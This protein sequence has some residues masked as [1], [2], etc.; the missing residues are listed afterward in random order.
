MNTQ[1]QKDFLIH[2]AYWSLIIAAVYL[3][4][5]YLLPVSVPFILGILIAWL[6]VQI[7]RRIH[8]SSK[9]LRIGIS[10]LIYGLIGALMT[11]IL[12]KSISSISNIL[13]WLPGIYEDK[14]LPFVTL[15]YD[16]ITDR[17]HMMGPDVISTLETLVDDLL[18]ALKNVIAY[19]SGAAV[20][21]VSGIATG[22]PSLILSILAMIFSTMFVVADYEQILS[23]A[24]ENTP[25]HIKKVLYNI[26]RYLTDTLFVVI[27]S[28]VLIMLLTFTEL[29][30]L[31]SLFDF[32]NSVPKAAIIAILDILP[33]LGTGAVMIPWMVISFAL[34]STSLG[35]KLLVIYVIVT[36]VRNY[37]EPKIVGAQLGQHP[38]I[39]L[40][41]M[42]I[43][44]RLFGFWGLFGLPVGISFLWKQYREKQN[45]MQ[46]IEK[47]DP[48]TDS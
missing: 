15:C 6:V 12:A 26:R 14:L 9:L 36:V 35:L 43:G 33:I 47:T 29:T 25:K 22:V 1:Q 46:T 44:L 13:S 48:E 16:W 2:V 18:S 21:L 11:L 34:G 3:A 10:V 23:F 45:N 37:V 19:L 27:R 31:F 42:F 4:F 40:V 32:S 5:E 39:T 7:S 38:I 24:S 28:Y 17:I 20:N 8:C 41:A 30:I